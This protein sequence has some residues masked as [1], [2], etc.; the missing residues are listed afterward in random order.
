VFK[1]WESSWTYKLPLG[2][3]AREAGRQQRV[4][5]FGLGGEV[6]CRLEGTWGD[7]RA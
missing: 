3:C 1:L 6:G 5:E 7:E 4:Q 2:I